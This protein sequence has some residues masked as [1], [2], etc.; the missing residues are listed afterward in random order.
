MARKEVVALVLLALRCFDIELKDGLNA[1]FPKIDEK[2]P[3]LGV[4]APLERE[5]LRLRLSR[6]S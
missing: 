3:S 1:V 4:L 2:K 6:T 5:D